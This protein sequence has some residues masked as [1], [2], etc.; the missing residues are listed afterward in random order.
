[1]EEKDLLRLL[2]GGSPK[3]FTEI[4]NRYWPALYRTAEQILQEPHAAHD[5]VQEVFVALWRRR[6]SCQIENLKHFLLQSV[7]FQACKTIRT[8]NNHRRFQRQ[9]IYTHLPV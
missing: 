5:C 8:I 7:R 4:Y 1:M 2:S 3:A 6:T 9:Y